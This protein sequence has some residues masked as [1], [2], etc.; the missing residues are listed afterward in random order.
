MSKLMGENHNTEAQNWLS[1]SKSDPDQNCCLHRK[2][3]VSWSGI[4]LESN[5]L[6][7]TEAIE[8]QLYQHNMSI[9]F[10]TQLSIQRSEKLL[11]YF[12]G[13]ILD[14]LI[15]TFRMGLQDLKIY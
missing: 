14:L 15:K 6:K 11:Y 9:F 10:Y 7:K 4:Y 5:S 13:S 1:T 3:Q 12:L 2:K 8:M